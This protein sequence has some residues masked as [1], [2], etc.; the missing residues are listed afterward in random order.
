MIDIT[1]KEMEYLVSKGVKF[2]EGGICKTT[3]HHNT[4]HYFL[5]ESRWNMQKHYEYEKKIGITHEKKK[6]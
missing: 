1:K 6:R 4:K 3:S 2:G 5:C